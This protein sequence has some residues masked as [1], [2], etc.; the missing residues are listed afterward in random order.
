MNKGKIIF[1][2]ENESFIE[3]LPPGVALVKKTGKYSAKIQLNKKRETIGRFDTPEEAGQAYIDK[4]AEMGISLPRRHKGAWV[5]GEVLHKAIS[6]LQ[7][8]AETFRW[9]EELHRAKP[10]HEKADRNRDLAIINEDILKELR[11]T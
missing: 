1:E 10:D 6:A 3:A 4:A 7:T 9:Y 8:N 11:E 5:K 2:N